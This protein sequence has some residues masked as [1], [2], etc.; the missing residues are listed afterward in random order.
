MNPE[1]IP[2]NPLPTKVTLG[3]AEHFRGIGEKIMKFFPFLP[4][5][6]KQAEVKIESATYGAII[7]VL[8]GFYFIFAVI[9][10][11]IFAARLSPEN[12][13]VAPLAV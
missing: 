6:L 3:I 9:V 11:Y 12:V 7:F 13:V 4:T 2:L 8:A 10:T 1:K 5:E